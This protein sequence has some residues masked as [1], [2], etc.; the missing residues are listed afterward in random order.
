MIIICLKEENSLNLT[1]T[2]KNKEIVGNVKDIGTVKE[3]KNNENKKS[4]FEDGTSSTTT[5]DEDYVN[6]FFNSS[7]PEESPPSSS[8]NDDKKDVK[9]EIKNNDGSD[10]KILQVN[11]IEFSEP[12]IPVVINYNDYMYR[13][14]RNC[15][16]VNE[17]PN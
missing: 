12:I 10:D 9:K 5:L 4:I 8:K 17:W 6:T 14:F 2:L 15:L 7:F 13:L 16:N 3:I 11:K 1:K